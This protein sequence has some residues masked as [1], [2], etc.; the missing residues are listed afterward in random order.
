MRTNPKRIEQY[1]IRTG[2]YAS[3]ESFGMTGAFQIPYQ[4]VRLRVLSSDGRDWDQCGLAPPAW[5]HVSVS[6]GARCP[7]REE[8]DFVKRL[9]WRDDETVIQ[10]HVP[11]ESHINAHPYCLHLWKPIG[12]ELPLPPLT[13]VAPVEYAG[14]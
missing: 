2:D 11:R 7:T 6:L 10:M 14:K 8:M 5:E 9:F 4:Q 13:T 3:D 12:V 1:R